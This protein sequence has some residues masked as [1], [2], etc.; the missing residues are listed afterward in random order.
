MWIRA[1]QVQSRFK[2]GFMVH[3]FFLKVIWFQWQMEKSIQTP[4]G[5]TSLQYCHIWKSPQCQNINSVYTEKCNKY[6]V[7]TE[8]DLWLVV[9]GIILHLSAGSFSLLESDT[10]QDIIQRSTGIFI[11][12]HNQKQVK[13]VKMKCWNMI[14]PNLS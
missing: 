4:V 7:Q 1:K 13:G 8:I 11:S 2:A 14:C 6:P 12:L 9:R 5:F 3:G 10:W